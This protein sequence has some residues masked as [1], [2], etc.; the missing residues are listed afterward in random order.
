M[1]RGMTRRQA[2]KTGALAAAMVVGVPRWALAAMSQ[3]QEVPFTDMPDGFET[4]PTAIV[5]FVDIRRIDEFFTPADEFFTIQ[6]YGQPDIDVAT[7][8]VEISGLVTHPQALS[9]ADIRRRPRTEIACAFECS[10]NS[11]RRFN[12]LISNGLWGGTSLRALLDDVGVEPDGKEVVFF[13]ADAGTE[14]IESRGNSWQVDQQYARSLS[15]ADAMRDD[16][17][18]AYELNGE[19][20]SLNQGSPLRLIVPGWYGVAQ[21]KWLNQIHVQ[22]DRFMG[23]FMAREYVTLTAEQVGESVKYTE[24]SITRIQLKSAIAKVTRGAGHHTIPGFALNDGTPLRSV[25]VKVDDGPWRPATL[26]ERNTKY[27]WKL[28]SVR[29]EGA[30]PGEHTIVSRV[31]DAN[32]TVQPVLEDLAEKRTSWENNA[33]FARTVMIS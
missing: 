20:L 9:V 13:G 28:F 15:L 2:A 19:P 32:G 21:V 1:E 6:H 5:R 17:L 14:T 4:D 24:T 12:G 7:H 16:A 18:L 11:R 31:T 8:A 30:K 25:E 27:S 3:E 22:A 26:D 33:Q 23:K 10:G 29:W